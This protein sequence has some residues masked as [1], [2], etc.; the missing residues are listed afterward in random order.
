MEQPTN[1]ES[2]V[3]AERH[4]TVIHFEYVASDGNLTTAYNVVN[5]EALSYTVLT[6]RAYDYIADQINYWKRHTPDEADVLEFFDRYSEAGYSLV[7]Q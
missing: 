3:F 1:P 2:V 4:I 7:R 6:G 5:S